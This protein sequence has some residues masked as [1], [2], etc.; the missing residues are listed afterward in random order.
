MELTARVDYLY[1]GPPSRRGAVRHIGLYRWRPGVGQPDLER[2]RSAL[3]GVRS[4]CPMLRG[5]A[6][7][8][9]LGLGTNHHD[10]AVEAQVDDLAAL[11]A[12]FADA[13]Q[14]RV[15]AMLDDLAEPTS[16][17]RLQHRML[18]G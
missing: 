15:A 5:L 8:P 18:S 2:V 9:D 12:F 6:Y 17:A 11:G 13:A 16:T 7:G 14:T 10:W 1:S 4:A 3:D